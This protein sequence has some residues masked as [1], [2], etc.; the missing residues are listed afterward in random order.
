LRKQ[1]FVGKKTNISGFSLGS[2]KSKTQNENY[3]S[4]N[5]KTNAEKNAKYLLQLIV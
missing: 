2:A 3:E 5:A 4:F 1:G